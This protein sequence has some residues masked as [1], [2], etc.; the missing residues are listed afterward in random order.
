MARFETETFRILCIGPMHSGKTCFID[1]MSSALLRKIT[2]KVEGYGAYGG[3]NDC[4]N[5]EMFQ[6]YKVGDK[7]SNVY[8]GDM[9]GFEKV[10][11]ITKEDILSIVEGNIPKKFSS[12]DA[13]PEVQ[14]GKGDKIHCVCV[15]FDCKSVD[16]GLPTEVKTTINTVLKVLSKK[17]IP[18]IVILT[19]GD[20]LSENI[21]FDKLLVYESKH[22]KRCVRALYT[23]FNCRQ[24]VIFPVINYIKESNVDDACDIL[25]LDALREIL[26][27]GRKDL[28][29]EKASNYE[30][31]Q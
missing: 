17:H 30:S 1:S 22:V 11:G 5:T 8:F 13:T 25:L 24:N 20:E 31:D 12:Q 18:Y 4:P 21:Q 2:H 14:L 29:E 9:P 6:M 27:L 26:I 15:V 10:D 28:E 7:R 23:E 19:K 16:A 3:R